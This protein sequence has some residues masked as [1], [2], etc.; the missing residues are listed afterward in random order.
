MEWDEE[1]LLQ[2]VGQVRLNISFIIVIHSFVIPKQL[3][4]RTRKS[5]VF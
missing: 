3:E 1:S 2:Y 5:P 4:R